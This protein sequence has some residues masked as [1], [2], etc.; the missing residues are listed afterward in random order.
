[1]SMPESNVRTTTVGIIGAGRIGHAIARLAVRAGRTTVMSN[2]KG[3]DSLRSLARELGAS[4]RA[5]SVKEA[6]EQDI[7]VVAVPWDRVEEALYRLPAWNGRI[8]VDAT[9]AVIV[10]G[11]R[12]VDLG[13]RAS[14]EV[15][16]SLVPGARVVKG[17][18]TLVAA[19]LASDPSVSGGQR[20]LFYS[21][22]DVAAKQGF[23]QLATE[24]GFAAIDLGNLAASR[25]QQFPGP[26]AAINFIKVP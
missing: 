4:V 8:V 26:L 2:S 11:Y 5:G 24:A 20:V 12:A 6:A 22:D 9:N 14:S 18:N 19:V 1:M 16:A 25:V 13:C 15:F 21:G 17:F 3:P 10:P 23:H 7:V